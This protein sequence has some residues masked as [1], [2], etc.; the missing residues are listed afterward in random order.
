[1]RIVLQLF[2]FLKT[3]IMAKQTGIITLKGTIGS[4]SFYKNKFGHLAREKGGVDGERIK[5]DP[6]FQRTRENGAEFG[7]AGK[8]GRLMRTALKTLLQNGKDGLVVSR[9]TTAMLK[10]IQANTTDARGTRTVVSGEVA[11]LDNFN[12]NVNAPITSTLF[13]P[14][15]TTV[16]RATGALAVNIPALIPANDVAAPEGT[17]HFKIVSA[18]LDINFTDEVFTVDADDSGIL[19][20]DATTSGV[21]Q[22]SHT[23][24]ANSTNP[25]VIVLGLQF[26]QEV[27]GV[28]YPLKNGNYNSLAV[29]KVS[30]A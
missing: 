3:N 9:L 13:A 18:G 14:Y 4:L 1:V 28:Q 12:F 23:V 24:P 16:D 20:Y 10:V 27:N 6:A 17:T 26:Y 22:L 2:I 30:V 25:L 5:T 15:T 8:A 7:R 29:V 11:L 21:I 19:P